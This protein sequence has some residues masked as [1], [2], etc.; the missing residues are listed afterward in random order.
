MASI[1]WR[2]YVTFG[3]ISIPIRLFRAARPERVSLRRLY[4]GEAVPSETPARGQP[5]EESTEPGAVTDL[6]P[7]QQVSVR[8]GTDEVVPK[9]SMV[10]GYEYGKDH[11]VAIEPEE[12]K[13]LAPKT[14]SSMEI[15]EF[16]KLED[17]D[18]V[19]FETSYYANPEEAG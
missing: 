13:S 7:V 17:I 3:L 12:L 14:S 6:A 15:E 4:R 5:L 18:P 8:K 1:V 2:G 19:Y 9:Q 11:F 16:V 10:K